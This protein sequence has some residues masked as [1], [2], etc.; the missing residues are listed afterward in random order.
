MEKDP[1]VLVDQD[2]NIG[3]FNDYLLST[4]Y[5]VKKRERER[6]DTTELR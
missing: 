6:E 5:I 3:S 2:H 1:G 4:Y